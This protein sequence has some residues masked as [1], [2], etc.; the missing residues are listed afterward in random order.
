VL[1][2]Q[3]KRLLCSFLVCIL[4]RLGIGSVVEKKQLILMGLFVDYGMGYLMIG[5]WICCGE[6]AANID[7]IIRGLGNG[8]S[9]GLKT[10]IFRDC[11]L[12]P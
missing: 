4:H 1:D 3:K 12:F 8:I 9:Y 5:N 10:L 2:E 6:K 7:G 11:I